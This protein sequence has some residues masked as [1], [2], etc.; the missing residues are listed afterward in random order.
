MSDRVGS[1]RDG[2]TPDGPRIV[3]VAELERLAAVMPEVE[4]APL[5]ERLARARALV[6]RSGGAPPSIVWQ[7]VE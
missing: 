6:R 7:V 1:S 5:K 4:R 2:A 3:L